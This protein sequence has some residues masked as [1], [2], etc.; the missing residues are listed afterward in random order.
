MTEKIA[1]YQKAVI[2]WGVDAQIFKLL[3]EM[4]ELSVELYHMKD[5]RQNNVAEE[6]ADVEIVMEQLRDYFNQDGEIDQW[7]ELKLK[8][9]DK[10]V[11]GG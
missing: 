1:V 11:N 6:F 9:L 5:N 7:K 10:I 2:K 8:R 3:E 4:S